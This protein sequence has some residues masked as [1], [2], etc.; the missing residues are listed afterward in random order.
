[1]PEHSNLDIPEFLRRQSGERQEVWEAS[2]KPVPAPLP[3]IKLTSDQQWR[4]DRDAMY[5]QQA[6]E[7]YAA[8]E[9]K[10]ES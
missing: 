10:D 4:K 8:Q 2:R 5:A 6:A 7:Y 1:M 9:P 3:G